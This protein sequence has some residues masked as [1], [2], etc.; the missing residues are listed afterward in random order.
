[1][2]KAKNGEEFGKPWI[3]PDALKIRKKR[4]EAKLIYD[5]SP[6]SEADRRRSSIES[7]CGWRGAGSRKRWREGAKA[8][9][10][11]DCVYF[12]RMA[13]TDAYKIGLTHHARQRLS[14]IGAGVPVPVT[15]EGWVSFFDNRVLG[16]AESRAHEIADFYGERLKGEWFNLREHHVIKIID[17]LTDGMEDDVM[18]VSYTGDLS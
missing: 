9:G 11:V 14:A 1:M 3:N 2:T 12:I 4:P 13:G 10:A 17:A 16:E 8:F 15:L 7:I 6:E 18:G 5:S